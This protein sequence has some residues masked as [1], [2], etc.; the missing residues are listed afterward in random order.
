MYIYVKEYALENFMK[1]LDI[2]KFLICTVIFF[3]LSA[4]T[5][6]A[7]ETHII[8][9]FDGGDYSV[10][11]SWGGFVSVLNFSCGYL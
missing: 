6:N 4:F 7:E 3:S 10:V 2:I 9:N 1:K 8:D 11:W 5:V